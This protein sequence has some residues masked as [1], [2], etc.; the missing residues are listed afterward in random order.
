MTLLHISGLEIELHRKAIKHLYI[1]VLP[2]DGRVQVSAAWHCSEAMIS[3]ALTKRM[4]WIRRQQQR[5]R[6][7]PAQATQ[8]LDGESHAL[9][10]QPYRLQLIPATIRP[11]VLI[12]GDRLQLHIRPDATQDARTRLLAGFYRTQLHAQVPPLL[13]NWQARIGVSTNSWHIKR[14]KTRWGTC[15][16]QAKRIWLNLELAKQPPACLE[17]VLVH[18]LIHLLEARHNARFYRFMDQFL[19]DWR[20]HK[21]CLQHTDST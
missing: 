6:Q 17:Y 12:V 20:V 19:P 9:W 16:I 4:T 14:M 3:Q 11:K 18:E 2:P 15:N 8:L 5:I 10:G 1:R 7:R 21:A 13:D